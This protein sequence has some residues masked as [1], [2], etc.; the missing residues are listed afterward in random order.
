VRD[1]I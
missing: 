1:E